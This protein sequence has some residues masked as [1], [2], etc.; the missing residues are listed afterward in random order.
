LLLLRAAGL[1]TTA[2]ELTA[3]EVTVKRRETERQQQMR[4]QSFGYMQQEEQQ[5]AW[6]PLTVVPS[7]SAAADKLW[8]KLLS[9][10]VEQ[11]DPQQQ[12]Q[13]RGRRPRPVPL[14]RADYLKAFVP[15]AAGSSE[16][17]R[18][19]PQASFPAAAGA[20]AG[21]GTSA[22][23]AAAGGGP[24]GASTSPSP[25]P[26][27]DAGG[28]G[29]VVLPDGMHK[30]VRPFIKALFK[31]HT[32]CSMANVRQ[33]LQQQGD[34]QS[35]A[36]A[37]LDD[38]LLHALLMGSGYCQTLRRVYIARDG[39]HSEAQEL[40]QVRDGSTFFVGIKSQSSGAVGVV[41]GTLGG[42]VRDV[43]TSFWH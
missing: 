3:V 10:D 8:D 34:Q 27:P 30:A 13:Q 9:P 23:A 36:A 38:Q 42:Q 7:D 1:T 15:S 39:P 2:E 35:V 29:A 18:G 40:R 25:S 4:L 5:E 24:G 26:A 28:E 31:R 43:S 14:S 6:V 19:V 20:R 41:C 11:D 33:W 22:A 32:V 37:A 21:A 16:Y 17:S 12:Q